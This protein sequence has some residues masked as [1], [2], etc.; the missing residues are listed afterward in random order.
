M[1]G[2]LY[3]PPIIGFEQNGCQE[4]QLIGSVKRSIKLSILCRNDKYVMEEIDI[5]Y[6]IEYSKKLK[7]TE[8]AFN[9]YAA[10]LKFCNE[11]T[12][13]GLTPKVLYSESVG[14]IVTSEEFINRKLH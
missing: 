9:P 12:E 1:D 11:Y 8:K 6:L 2:S 14:F 4:Q 7:H 10:A 5:E 13:N 3:G